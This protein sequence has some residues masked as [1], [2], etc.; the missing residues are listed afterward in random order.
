M[1]ARIINTPRSPQR[2]MTWTFG[3]S[4]APENSTEFSLDPNGEWYDEEVEAPVVQTRPV[5][6]AATKRRTQVSRR[7]HVV[8]KQLYRQTYLDEMLRWEGHGDARCG[9]SCADCKAHRVEEPGAAAIR[10]LDCFV[11]DLVCGECCVRRHRRNPLHHVECWTGTHFVKTTLKA[12]GL[13]IQLNHLSMQCSAPVACNTNMRILH[14]NGIHDVAVEYC[15][16]RP[17]PGH[18]QLLR[19]GFYPASQLTVKTCA[20]FELLRHLHLMALST[21]GLTYHF[22]RALE[23]ST[24]NTGID[25]PKSRYRALLRM[26][27]QW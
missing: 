9:E 26:S 10:C 8:W 3:N 5:S 18:I 2:G 7:P 24:N 25:M 27:L 13:K 21:K 1:H 6:A 14:T 17:L 23:K 4:W 22:Y 16:C 20:T 11:P 19:R 15:G 12:L